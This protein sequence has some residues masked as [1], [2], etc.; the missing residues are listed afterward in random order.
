MPLD[1]FHLAL[2]ACVG[3]AAGVLGGLLGIG[4]SVIMIP[5]L[6]LLVHDPS[7]ESQHLYQA[8]AMAVNVAVSLPAA[9][10]HRRSGN[11]RRDVFRLMLPSAACG[12][13]VGVL[14]SNLL[15]GL[16]LRRVFAAFLAYNAAAE[17]V[18]LLRQRPDYPEEGA[19]VTP[20]R[21]IIPGTVMGLAAG[22]LGIGGGVIGIPILRRAAHLPLRQCIGASSAVMC[23]TAIVGAGLKTGTLS[24]HGYAPS[25]AVILAA[26][27]APTAV[28]GGLLGAGLTQRLPLQAIRG[29][30]IVLLAYSAYQMAGL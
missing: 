10:R 20:A 15:P 21:I 6:A 30:M 19:L 3:L 13:V 16:A 5:A 17:L 1:T 24:Q 27:L 9:L 7:A 28:I 25:R 4:G 12:I 26:L 8:A 29:A 2:I 11:V 22:L 18:G 23:L 14:A